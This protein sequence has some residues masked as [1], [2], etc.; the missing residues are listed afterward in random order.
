MADGI[1]HID[2]DTGECCDPPCPDSSDPCECPEDTCQ[3]LW[4]ATYDCVSQVWSVPTSPDAFF[5]T[6]CIESCW[7]QSGGDPC[8]AFKNTCEDIGCEL[9][10]DCDPADPGV[11]DPAVPA[12][13]EADACEPKVE[14]PPP[15]CCLCDCYTWT[16]VLDCSDGSWFI[17]G[18]VMISGDCA[19]IGD[20][21]D[22]TGWVEIDDCAHME[23]TICVADGD[24]APPQPAD[25]PV[26]TDCCECVY[27]YSAFYDCDAEPPAWIPGWE[28]PVIGSCIFDCNDTPWVTNPMD[29]CQKDRQLCQS[30]CIEVNDCVATPHPGGP[31]AP[32]ANCCPGQKYCVYD[33]SATW[34]CDLEMNIYTPTG[35]L[36]QE[37]VGNMPTWLATGDPCV[38]TLS[39]EETGDTCDDVGDCT[40]PSE[41]ETPADDNPLGCCDECI[42]YYQWTFDCDTGWGEDLGSV[43]CDDPNNPIFTQGMNVWFPVGGD[44]CVQGIYVPS[45]VAC[46]EDVDC[47]G[48]PASPNPPN[49][50]N[51]PDDCDC[52][53]HVEWTLEGNPDLCTLNTVYGAIIGNVPCEEDSGWVADGDCDWKYQQYIAGPCPGGGIGGLTPPGDQPTA[54]PN[55]EVCCVEKYCEEIWAVTFDCEAEPP[56]WTNLTQ[57]GISCA[58]DC[59]G[60]LPG[61]CAAEDWNMDPQDDCRAT[62]T[63]CHQET[64]N[65][66]AD[67]EYDGSPPN[68]PPPEWGDVCCAERSCEYSWSTT[69]DCTIGVGGDWVT[70]ATRLGVSCVADCSPSQPT[71]G[72]PGWVTNLGTDPCFAEIV[73]CSGDPCE[74][75]GDCPAQNF[76]PT[77]DKPVG[78][79]T[80]TCCDT[81][82][83][84]HE[85]TYNCESE[86]PAWSVVDLGKQCEDSPITSPYYNVWE[87]YPDPN[88]P[89]CV[90]RQWAVDDPPEACVNAATCD[91]FPPSPAEPAEDPPPGCCDKSCVLTETWQYFCSTGTWVKQSSDIDCLGTDGLLFDDWLRIGTCLWQI[92]QDLM[93]GCTEGGG[94]CDGETPP[95]IGPPGFT[96]DEDGS[97]DRCEAVWSGVFD[98]DTMLWVYGGGTGEPDSCACVSDCD[99]YTYVPTGG[100]PCEGTSVTCAV[101]TAG[102]PACG[103]GPV[104]YPIPPDNCCTGTC[105]YVYS[106]VWDCVLMDWGPVNPVAT[107]TCEASCIDSGGWE[108]IGCDA[109]WT[110]C[111]PVDE[112]SEDNDCLSPPAQPVDPDQDQQGVC[113]DIC[114]KT[115]QA[116]FFCGSGWNPFAFFSADCV[117]PE[118]CVESGPNIVG[119]IAT[120]VTCG[121]ACDGTMGGA[122]CDDSE[123]KPDELETTPDDCCDCRYEWTE[124]YDCDEPEWVLSG[125]VALGCASDCVADMDWNDTGDDCVRTRIACGSSCQIVGSCTGAELTPPAVDDPMDAP[126]GC[127]DDGICNAAWSSEWDCSIGAQGDWSAPN[128]LGTFCSPSC[129]DNGWAYSGPCGAIRT[130]CG[131][132]CDLMVG[133]CPPPSVPSYPEL[134][135]PG[136]PGGC[137]V[138]PDTCVYTYVSAYDCNSHTW[139]TVDEPFSGIC[140]DP[141]GCF[142]TDGWVAVPG[143]CVALNTICVENACDDDSGECDSPPGGGAPGSLAPDDICCPGDQVCGEGGG[144]T[145][146]TF[147][148]ALCPDTEPGLCA[149]GCYDSFADARA[150]ADGTFGCFGDFG[151]GEN[152]WFE[153][154]S[155]T[156]GYIKS[157]D[158]CGDQEPVP[159]GPAP[160]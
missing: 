25:P 81:C 2:K 107:K 21:G 36:C 1:I 133:I 150:A 69:F 144:T 85:A 106:A 115:W 61:S 109:T 112:C 42:Y 123:D 126:D 67:C 46:E 29:D 100:E 26:P 104:G 137:C 118:G 101:A 147:W 11:P 117:S 105:K 120:Q 134:A 62:L 37:P 82:V 54:P 3:Y 86:P 53:C 51:A 17:T 155:G 87:P 102:G 121:Q 41:P 83:N 97:S 119:C 92:R 52:C 138:L 89:S 24:P 75:N 132:G 111:G 127:C 80:A 28:T 76:N 16:A 4:A 27:G 157:G 57:E 114:Q 23:R 60:C 156:W 77:P 148:T 130:T 22:D 72:N 33:W 5:C 73:S 152:T 45:G 43:F 32:D 6:E 30:D 84:I 139:G 141:F 135:E 49:F 74:M 93:V 9:D 143:S 124:T 63:R 149:S 160:C 142:S 8:I 7:V 48:A 14:T 19:V 58:V 20:D 140:S 34:D 59:E 98:C 90:W 68:F 153:Y 38:Y 50:P 108:Y 10:E 131:V 146:Y 99:E 47:A 154:G 158:A 66:T 13:P 31:G 113:C 94:E 159:P 95:E 56:E 55:P 79:P 70:P 136:G 64:C 18:P 145:C 88:T 110:G 39:E 128:G 71:P 40:P 151:Q 78:T 91:D 129:T 44:D 35:T 122:D 116:A 96:L 103:V 125:P 65:E 15:G 12:D